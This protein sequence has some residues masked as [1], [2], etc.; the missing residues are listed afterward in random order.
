[1]AK[2]SAQS[3]NVSKLIIAH[4][5]IIANFVHMKKILKNI[6]IWYYRR[7]YT[8][9]VFAYLEHESTSICACNYAEFAFSEITGHS[10]PDLR[11][12]KDTLA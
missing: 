10:Y 6:R 9:L 7:L 2:Y 11:D 8:K 5:H 12:G 3:R 1:M 4:H